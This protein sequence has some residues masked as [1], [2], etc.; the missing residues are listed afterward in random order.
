MTIGFQNFRTYMEVK[1]QQLFA[2]ALAPIM[3]RLK[4]LKEEQDSRLAVIKQE[5][6]LINED[7]ILHATRSAGVSFAQ[8][9]NF[10]MEGALSSEHNRRTM[11]EEL[12]AFHEYCRRS[13]VCSDEEKL[14]TCF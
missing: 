11:E 1:I 14:A 8:S 3:M 10:L 9:F 6:E 12:R 13:G 2:D 4:Q 5:M 7:N